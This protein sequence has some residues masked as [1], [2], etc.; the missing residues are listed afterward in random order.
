MSGGECQRAGIAR[1]LAAQPRLLIADECVA[2]LDVTT[3]SQIVE[4]L[5]ELRRR[6]GLTL[7]FIAHDLGIVRRLCERVVVLRRGEI[8]EEGRSA[9]LFA[10]PRHPHTAALIAASPRLESAQSFRHDN[11]DT[12]EEKYA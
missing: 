12:G 4:L 5:G 7:L 8:V 6:M 9:E 2:G 3:Q 11:G 10:R 1:A